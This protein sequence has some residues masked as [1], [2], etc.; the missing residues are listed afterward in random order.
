MGC[1]VPSRDRLDR[2]APLMILRFVRADDA[3]P[4]EHLPGAFSKYFRRIC[5]L[6]ERF[7]SQS[8]DALVS[9]LHA[10][11]PPSRTCP[12]RLALPTTNAACF[13]RRV[14][15][16]GSCAAYAYY[17]LCAAK[18]HSA[19]CPDAMTSVAL[20][21]PVR[22]LSDIST[23]IAIVH[24]LAT[25]SKP[26]TGTFSAAWLSDVQPRL[27]ASFSELS[28]SLFGYLERS[29]A[30]DPQLWPLAT[31]S[32]VACE[33]ARQRLGRDVEQ[34]LASDDASLAH[35]LRAV[36]ARCSSTMKI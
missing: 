32:S 7:A 8:W 26:L 19:G 5:L 36:T 12:D 23:W 29:F 34:L 24:R 11:P 4:L 28:P 22:V 6:I 30:D 10:V 20:D 16:Q 31:R 33:K 1:I 17:A 27:I 15:G 21:C 13:H 35:M 25:A 2:T 14:L 9:M 3:Y 18:R